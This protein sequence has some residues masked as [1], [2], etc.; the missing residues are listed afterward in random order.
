MHGGEREKSTDKEERRKGERA[1]PD[2]RSNA[3]PIGDGIPR[4]VTTKTL[5]AVKSTGINGPNSIP[6]S[7]LALGVSSLE[8]QTDFAS[9]F[10]RQGTG[11]QTARTLTR[12]PT[13]L[14]AT[15]ISGKAL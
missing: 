12:E 5:L 8:F 9:P 1:R 11:E 13:P 6:L 3:R 14:D 2:R 10:A 7:L 15:E 4:C